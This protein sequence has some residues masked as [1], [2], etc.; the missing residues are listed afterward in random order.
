MSESLMGGTPE[1]S[2]TPPVENTPP[3]DFVAPEW[4]KG[5]EVEPELL[6][7]P[8]LKAIKDAPSLLKSYVH[9]QRKMGMDKV[10]IPNKNSTKEEWLGFYQK[11]GLPSNLE[12]YALKTP[13]KPV[14][15]EEL[16]NQFKQKAY[17]ANLLP[18][19]ASAMLDFLNGYTAEQ[20]AAMEQQ[21]GNA[22]EEAV[23]GLKSEW[24]DAFDQNL[25][26]AKLAVLEFGGQDF[27]AYLNESGLGNDPQLIKAFSK[28]GDSFF[29]EDKFNAEGKPA[30]SMSPDEAQA[31]INTIMGD[32]NGPYFNAMHPD[33]KRTV[34]EVQK[35]YQM[36]YRK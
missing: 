7:D 17:E 14:F 15:N 12:E 26:K 10:V 22:L 31:K 8:S 16:I 3:Q 34:D 24:G 28:I 27:Q 18:D 32:F 33:H 35:L 20:A 36:A 21:Q 6:Q 19:Q 23:N 30:Y 29:K 9:A 2:N 13:E 5:W 1:P 4:A 25:R 11:L